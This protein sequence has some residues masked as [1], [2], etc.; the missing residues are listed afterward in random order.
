MEDQGNYFVYIQ[1]H[2]ELFEKRSVRIGATDG[3]RTEIVSGA[4]ITDR[5]ITQ[6]AILVKLA[7]ATGTLDAHSG[8]N[9]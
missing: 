6:G 2:P 3:I 8:H 9:H 7:Q 4:A 1:I 5:I